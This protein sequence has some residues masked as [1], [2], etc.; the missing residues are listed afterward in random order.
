MEGT[1]ASRD[2]R[3]DLVAQKLSR[4]IQKARES[5]GADAA[6]QRWCL[7]SNFSSPKYWGTLAERTLKGIPIACFAAFLSRQTAVADG[8]LARRRGEPHD[9]ASLLLAR[10]GKQSSTGLG[11]TG[12]LA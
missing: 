8:L 1:P 5:L 10:K 2:C 11:K 6:A 12:S 3:S 4:R 7:V 9:E